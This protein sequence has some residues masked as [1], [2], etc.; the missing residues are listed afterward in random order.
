MGGARKHSAHRIQLNI[1]LAAAGSAAD[2]V[3]DVFVYDAY[4]ESGAGSIAGPT[5]AYDLY[6][7]SIVE[8]SVVTLKNLTG[9][10]TNF[11]AYQLTQRDSAGTIK[12]QIAVSFNATGVAAVAY[13]AMNYAVAS[14]AVVPGAGTGTLTVLGGAAL[15][16]KLN[17][18][19]TVALERVSNNVTGLAT[20]AASA[21]LLIAGTG[22]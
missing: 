5:V 2:L 14:G 6:S 12:N 4:A 11:A 17:P 8:A 13:V 9:Q 21:T 10:A 18:G 22:A 3:G 16:W 19:D 15:P 1:P 20:P 7:E